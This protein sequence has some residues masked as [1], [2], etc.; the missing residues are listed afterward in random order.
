MLKLPKWSEVGWTRFFAAIAIV[1]VTVMLGCLNVSGAWIASGGNPFYTGVVFGVELLAATCLVLILAAPTRPRKIVGAVVF[2]LLVWVCVENGKMAV[3]ESFKTVF[4]ESPEALRNK[5]TIA[6]KSAGTLEATGPADLKALKEEKAK[7]EVEQEVMVATTPLG[8]KAAQTR[9]KALGLY[10]LPIDGI[11]GSET[12]AAMLARGEVI[13]KRLA[14]LAKQVDPVTG[15]SP[16]ENKAREAIEMRA[17]AAEIENR[18]VWMN[19]LLFAVEGARSAGLWAFVVW[20]M[21]KPAIRVD[22]AVF[23]DLQE[24]ADELAR[25]KANLETGA[26]KAVKTKTKKKKVAAAQLAI[27]DLRAEL[28]R[29]EEVG[30]EAEPN[31]GVEPEAE[32]DEPGEEDQQEKAA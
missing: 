30:D 3:K 1:I 11:N 29:R 4:T 12:Q 7:L 6:E 2:G 25:R 32:D 21:A 26:E 28:A 10:S 15:S 16:A 27:E 20:S 18:T 9:L 5:A 19:L 14:E 8:I 22:P 24:Q 17:K 13:S 31:E 23:K